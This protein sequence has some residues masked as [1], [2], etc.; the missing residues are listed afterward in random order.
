MDTV[1]AS[2]KPTL[3]QRAAQQRVQNAKR[4]AE[5]RER[6]DTE[7]AAN[8]TESINTIFERCFGVK[9]ER[10]Y[11]KKNDDATGYG[12][13]PY[14]G[15][16]DHEGMTFFVNTH[17]LHN[18]HLYVVLGRCKKCGYEIS[19]CLDRVSVL[20]ALKHLGECMTEGYEPKHTCPDDPEQW[21]V[22]DENYEVVQ[23]AVEKQRERC[24]ARQAAT[25]AAPLTDL[26]VLVNEIVGTPMEPAIV[27]IVAGI[28]AFAEYECSQHRYEGEA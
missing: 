24:A 15:W 27:Q 5:Q 13:E 21:L 14:Q 28:R 10:V 3:L 17:W 9:P 12:R 6:A 1:V 8:A 22:N 2:E 19:E 20:Y 7:F 23:A 16:A 25:I 18:A 26:Q 4:E 11:L